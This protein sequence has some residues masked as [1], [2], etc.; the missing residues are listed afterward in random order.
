MEGVA[1]LAGRQ[2]ATVEGR[3]KPRPRP[4]QKGSD[5]RRCSRC[6]S[7]SR[8]RR[9]APFFERGFEVD[10]GV[11]HGTKQHG[12]REKGLERLPYERRGEINN[13]I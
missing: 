13:E 4:L 5:A 12:S 1:D 2:P 7:T 6:T 9:T 3:G 11:E 8:A 10:E